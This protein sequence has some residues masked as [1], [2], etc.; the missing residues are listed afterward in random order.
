MIKISLNKRE[1]D[2]M[3]VMKMTNIST[4]WIIY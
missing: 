4:A 1:I 3:L 2:F